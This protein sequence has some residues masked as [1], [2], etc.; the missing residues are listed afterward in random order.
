MGGWDLMTA[1]SVRCSAGTNTLTCC[2]ICCWVLHKGD[3]SIKHFSL[4][5][6]RDAS[7][8]FYDENSKMAFLNLLKMLR[9]GFHN[10]L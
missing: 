1:R 8:Q 4:G 3:Q 6:F 2:T 7:L 9:P 5:V 10:L